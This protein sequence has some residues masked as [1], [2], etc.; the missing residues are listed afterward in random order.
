[1]EPLITANENVGVSVVVP[2]VVRKDSLKD[3]AETAVTWISYKSVPVLWLTTI[4]SLVP[5]VELVTVN[6][7][8]VGD[9]AALTSV[10]L[11]TG[12]FIVTPVVLLVACVTLEPEPAP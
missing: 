3:P 6:D 1:M 4:K 11:P 10:I 2:P 5:T 7:A 12:L 8:K 9:P